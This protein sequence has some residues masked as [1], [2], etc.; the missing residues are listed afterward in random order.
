MTNRE[1][2][3]TNEDFQEACKHVKLK[4]TTRQASKWKMRKGLAWKEGRK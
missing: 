3:K 1:F 4:P 2:A